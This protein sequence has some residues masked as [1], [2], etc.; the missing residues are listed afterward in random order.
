MNFIVPV[1]ERLETGTPANEV[2]QSKAADFVAAIPSLK[3][4]GQRI[5]KLYNNTRIH[6]RYL[7]IDFTQPD[8]VPFHTNNP[9]IQGR[10]QM[11]MEY[12]VPLVEQVVRKALRCTAADGEDGEQLD[13]KLVDAIGQIVVV[14]ST[15]F[16]APGLDTELIKRIGFRRD[17]AR[18]SVSFMGCAAAM[19]GL[20]VACDHVRAYPNHKV[21]LVCV[22]LS[23]VNALFADEINDVIIHSIF[24]DG[25][26][27]ALIGACTEEEAERQSGVI[28]EDHLS[29]LIENTEDGIVLGILDNG[30]T[31]KLS[32]Q[33]PDYIETNV[34][35]WLKGYLKHRGLRKED[36]DLWAVHPGG[37]RIIE[38]V[39]SCLGLQDDQ[40]ADSWATL[41]KY[42]NI[43]S[44]AVLFVI[45]RMLQRIEKESLQG[46]ENAFKEKKWLTGIAV[47]FAP[48][49]G[50]EGISFR[51]LLPH[52]IGKQQTLQSV[53][54][55]S[56][57]ELMNMTV[58]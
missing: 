14:S 8:A 47:S 51:T 31:C 46:K 26:A 10:M 19:N 17:I 3:G 36:I 57:T 24:G 35:N 45:K 34:G 49:V 21:L 2:L 28:I 58:C 5:H 18:V 39:Q 44:P 11:Y 20:R 23:S 50:V 33:L 32:R 6:T 30:I 52:A 9:S 22:E 55:N 15:G 29:Y 42:G 48:G 25:C 1:I 12:A 27:V 4:N 56:Q 7:A 13:R 54:E 53:Q 37:T 41:R 43:L 38:K 40:V 16:L